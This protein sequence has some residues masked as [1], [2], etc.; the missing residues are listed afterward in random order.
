MAGAE[1]TAA[2]SHETNRRL[3]RLVGLV[4]D[5]NSTVNLVSP[6]DLPR[7]WDRHILDSLRLVRHVDPRWTAA[8]L[9]S[10]AGFPGLVV[11]IACAMPVTLIE[12][13]KRKAA[14]LREAA[15]VT[16]CSA[17]VVADRVEQIG[18]RRFDLLTARGFAP[19]PALVAASRHLLGPDGRYLLL[20]GRAVGTELAHLDAS[21]TVRLHADK[22]G[23]PEGGHIVEIRMTDPAA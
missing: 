16:G 1:E 5:W 10:G 22:A 2:V 14:F 18:G 19:V 17:T 11:A 15:R 9:G 6:A 7:L 8:D 21:L 13:D 4:R 12:S 3:A 20:K 23:V